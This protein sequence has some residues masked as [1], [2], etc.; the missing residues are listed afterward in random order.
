MELALSDRAIVR[1]DDLAGRSGLPVRALQLL[2]REYVGVSPKWVIRRFWLQEAALRLAAGEPF[3]AAAVASEL[4]YFDQAHFIRDF[5]AQVGR[6]P[7][8][9]AAI[10]AA[11]ARR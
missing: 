11:A 9:Y 2:F 8:D 10:C 3:D 1:V 6:T 7:G 5:K 4:S